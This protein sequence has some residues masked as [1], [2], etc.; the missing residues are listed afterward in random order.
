M[1]VY[2]PYLVQ[3]R[4]G[5][6]GRVV[7]RQPDCKQQADGRDRVEGE[8]APMHEP[9]ELNVNHEDHE[10]DDHTAWRVSGEKGGST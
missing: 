4:E 7:H 1:E 5:C 10:G 9:D 8:A 2:C 6:E 3:V